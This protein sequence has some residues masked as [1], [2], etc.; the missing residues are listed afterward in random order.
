MAN[1]GGID[2]K[3]EFER[4]WIFGVAFFEVAHVGDPMK[5]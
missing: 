5:E 3:F 1:D 4:D 2:V